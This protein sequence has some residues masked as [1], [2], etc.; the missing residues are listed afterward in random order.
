[1][2]A[3]IEIPRE[4]FAQAE[5]SSFEGTY[6]LAC[7]DANPDRYR[8]TAPLQ[9]SITVQSTGKMLILDGTV[10]G[11]GNTACARCLDEF[12]IE[13]TGT[14]EGCYL[15]PGTPAPTDM[16]SDEYDVLPMNRIIDV[17][18]LII[19]ALLVDIPLVPLCRPD[20]RGI[21]PDCGI[22]L[23]EASCDCA[24]RRA[25]ARKQE[26]KAANPFAALEALDLGQPKE[27]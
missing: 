16:D 1:M 19:A 8:F 18:P 27:D 23:N 15:L 6:E 7:L 24:A 11:I 12:E 13:L 17:E 25:A 4:L 21:C 3:Y 20:C 9:W 10:S 2:P 26:E 22:N 14:I 5:S